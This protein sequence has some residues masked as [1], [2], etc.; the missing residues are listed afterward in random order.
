MR[1]LIFFSTIVWRFFI[2]RRIQR[3]VIKMYMGLHV[4]Y[5]IFLSDCNENCIYWRDCRKIF[6]YEHFIKICTVGA[7]GTRWRIWLRHCATNRKVAGSIPDGVT[8]IFHW[9]KPSGPTMTLGLTQPLTQMSTRN[10]SCQGGR[11]VGLTNLPHSCAD[12]LVIW[13]RQP[14]GTPWACPSL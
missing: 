1:V 2:L 9:H 6:K 7:L 13:E 14:L 12:C 8:G 5:P 3:D 11:C 4:E 10:N